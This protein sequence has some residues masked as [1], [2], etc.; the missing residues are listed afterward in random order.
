MQWTII[1]FW[2]MPLGLETAPEDV[3]EFELKLW[4]ATEWLI[5][6]APFMYRQM[7]STRPLDEEEKRT[8]APGPLCKDVPGVSLQRWAFWRWRLSEIAKTKTFT[9]VSA[10]GSSE[11]AEF[12]DESYSRVAQAIAA[13]DA[14]EKAAMVEDNEAGGAA[15]VQADVPTE[16]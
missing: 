14:A 11:Q 12:S 15:P 8:T 10:T 4:V 16:E 13:L 6:G 5:R 3:I 2:E 7:T 1:P 9:K